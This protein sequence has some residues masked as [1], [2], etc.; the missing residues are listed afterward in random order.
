MKINVS[1]YCN[2]RAGFGP[3]PVCFFIYAINYRDGMVI[4]VLILM[5][6]LETCGSER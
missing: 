6:M 1:S 4:T 5:K 2:M 3:M